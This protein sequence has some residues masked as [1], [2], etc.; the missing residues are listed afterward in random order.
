MGYD[1]S[2]KAEGRVEWP[3]LV[4]DEKHGSPVSCAQL[5]MGLTESRRGFPELLGQGGHRHEAG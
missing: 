1:E 3:W 4:R 2:P 5:L